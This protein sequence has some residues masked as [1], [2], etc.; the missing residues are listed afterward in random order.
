V[1]N[2]GECEILFQCFVTHRIR[3][4][5]EEKTSENAHFL[6]EEKPNLRPERLKDDGKGLEPVGVVKK[7]DVIYTFFAQFISDFGHA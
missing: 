7:S 6:G 2:C 1:L 4:G 5:C 3:F